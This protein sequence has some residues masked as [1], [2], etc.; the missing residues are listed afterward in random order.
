MR[1]MRIQPDRKPIRCMSRM[2][3]RRQSMFRKAIIVVLTAAT[4]L[5]FASFV[6]SSYRP[7]MKRFRSDE[8]SVD[9]AIRRAALIVS[10]LTVP[11]L[12]GQPVTMTTI[13]CGLPAA[14]PAATVRLPRSFTLHNP[15]FLPKFIRRTFPSG[16]GGLAILVIP[17]WIPFV[18]FAAYPTYAFVQSPSRRYRRRKRGLCI[19]C[20]YDLTGNVSG[21]CPECGT[22]CEEGAGPA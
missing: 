9:V 7:L 2:R 19:G 3:E 18:T 13:A 20:G 1:T 11:R 6:A 21:T 8:T 12:S 22:A 17:L 5:T 16:R 4:T 14:T 15:F 10:R